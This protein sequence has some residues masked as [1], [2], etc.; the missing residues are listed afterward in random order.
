MSKR[1]IVL[2]ILM[3]LLVAP[4]AYAE[5]KEQREARLR[6]ELAKIEVEISQQQVILDA[7]SGERQS[8]ERDVAV[9][10]VQI[11]KAQLAIRQRNLTISQITSDV[12]D[13]EQAIRELDAKIGREKDSLSQL[14]RKTNEI[15]NLSFTEMILGSNDLSDLFVDIDSFEVV[16]ISLSKSFELIAAAKASIQGQKKVL[17]EEQLE[18]RELREIQVLQKNKVESRKGEKN[19]ILTVTKGQE[20]IYQDILNES[21]RSAAEIRSTLFSLRGTAA[22]PFGD[23][24]DFAKEA[25]GKT[26]VRPALILAILKQETNLG[27]NVG[28]CLL[29]NSPNK[30]DGKG[31]NTGRAFDQVMKGTRDVDP[32][33]DIVNELG[34]DPYSQVVSCPPSYGYGGAM[35][36][37]QFIPSTWVLYKKALGKITGQNP[38]NPWDPR[39]AIFATALL[40]E[41]NGADQGSFFAER[42]AALRYFAGW[43]NAKKAAY[44]F[45]GDDVMELVEVMQNQID[46]LEG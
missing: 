27:E 28:Q 1:I 15:D 43:R 4:V 20:E 9:L 2:G 34:L 19:K 3:S 35:G 31:K 6:A 44:A 38:P 12:K 17:Q 14:L 40:M 30:G 45:Y 37:A 21:K 24:Y 25:S 22:I 26:G 29:T 32:F 39:T 23:A 11:N 10:D 8:L 13:R 16:K 42:L 7:K 36:P 41:D 46:I 33:M 5:T 18:E